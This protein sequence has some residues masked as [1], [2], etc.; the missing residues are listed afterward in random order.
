MGSFAETAIIDHCLSF[1]DQGK[2]SSVFVSV[3]SKQ[4]EIAFSVSSIC[5]IYKYIRKMEPNMRKA[6]LTDNSHFNLFAA[7]RNIYIYIYIYMCLCVFIC[8]YMLPLQTCPPMGVVTYIP[9]YSAPA[10]LYAGTSTANRLD[11]RENTYFPGIG[12]F[13]SSLYSNFCNLKS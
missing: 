9:C 5:H 11:S 6:E 13:G 10:V 12:C 7:N 8:I 3:C 2:H 1:S 4:T